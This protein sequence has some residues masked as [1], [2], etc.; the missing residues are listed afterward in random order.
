M[1]RVTKKDSNYLNCRMCKDEL[2][3]EENWSK[4]NSNQ[5]NFLC[6][7]CARIYYRKYYPKY[8]EPIERIINKR[9]KHSCQ[10][11]GEKRYVEKHH[12]DKNHKNN[13]V[14]NLVTLCPF[15]HKNIGRTKVVAVVSGGLDSISFAAFCSEILEAPLYVLTFAY[16]QRAT[17]E[18]SKIEEALQ[19]RIKEFKIV[20]I[21]SIKELF[22]DNQLTN[23]KVKVEGE[24][25]QSVVVPVRNAVMLSMASAYAYTVGANYIVYGA[26]TSDVGKGAPLYPDCTKGFQLAMEEAM[27]AGH[28]HF[29]EKGYYLDNY[30]CITSPGRLGVDKPVLAKWGHSIL[31]DKIF[32]TWSCY[33]NE[34]KQC[35]ICEACN[36][37]KAAF[38]LAGIADLTEYLV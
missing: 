27:Y 31:G 4:N 10:I 20:D 21:S 34:E 36:N 30:I 5:G 26:H 11:C 25:T 13:S 7:K 15:C 35:G 8:D 16:G 33:L 29:D 2:V 19:G 22:G 17:K 32:K 3:L 28:Y 18:M 6:N 38:N 14:E 24:Y 9:D 37:R 12:K 23:D 1:G